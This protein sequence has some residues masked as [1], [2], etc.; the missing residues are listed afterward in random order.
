MEVYSIQ[1]FAVFD[2]TLD[3]LKNFSSI[4]LDND[5]VKAFLSNVIELPK[6]EYSAWMGLYFA[7][8]QLPEGKVR[9]IEISVFAG[10]FYDEVTQVYHQLPPSIQKDWMN[11][12]SMNFK[13]I[14][15]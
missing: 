1:E 14:K 4:A 11:Y 6:D 5:T 3:T 15:K 10:F 8:C 2:Y 9:K 7:T 13:K 12:L